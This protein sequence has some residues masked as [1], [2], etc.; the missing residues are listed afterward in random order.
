MERRL[1]VVTASVARAH[2]ARLWLGEPG[3][4]VSTLGGIVLRPHQ[5]DAIDRLRRTLTE[6]RAALLADDVG[7]GKTYVAIALAAEARQP[8]IVGP[9]ALRAMWQ[10]ALDAAGVSARWLSYERLSR[11]DVQSEAADLVILDEAHHARTPSARRYERLATLTAGA[12]L[13]LLSAT[14]IHN[15][16]SDLTTLFALALGEG[17]R[18]LDDAALAARIVRRTHADVPE[19]PLPAV[20]SSEWIRVPDDDAVLQQ[21]LALPPPVPPRNGGDG[22]ALLAWTLVRL[23]ASTR[24]AL[25][26]ALRRRAQRGFALRQALLAGVLPSASELAA[27][28]CSDRAVQ[29]AFAELLAPPTEGISGLLSALE[30]HVEAVESLRGALARDD[31]PDRAR[32]DALRSLRASLPDERVIVFTQFVDSAASLWRRLRSEPGVAVLTARGAH[33]AGGPLSRREALR[34]FAPRATGAPRPA[35]SERIGLL[36]CTDLLSEGVNLQD[37]STVV[38]LDLPWTHARLAQ[39]VGRVRRMGSPHRAV[40]VYTFAP[41]AAAEHLL[42]VER[43]IGEKLG[44]AAR[45]L[46]VAGAILPSMFR[47]PD[48]ECESSSRVEERCRTL[49]AGWSA[50]LP[51]EPGGVCVAGVRAPA[52]GTLVALRAR[53]GIRLAAVRDGHVTDDPRAVFLLAAAADAA[54]DTA[55]DVPA[56]EEALAAVARWAR[57]RGAERSAGGVLSIGS[58]A[59]RAV[60]QRL[61]ATVA[62]SPRARRQEAA[63]LAARARRIAAI[64][65]GV[66]GE[67]VLGRL[68]AAAMPDEAWLRSVAAFA[69]AHGEAVAQRPEAVEVAE[70]V[71]LI[72]LLSSSR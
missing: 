20:A 28:Q 3:R 12:R 34:R 14:P 59:G 36:I 47:V 38:H 60:L 45:T 37:A 61:A 44:A 29:L 42:A 46:G 68:A 18:T 43:R 69:E 70:P 24:G 50:S 63:E 8:L 6:Y 65:I 17:A 22:G 53:E 49:I 71:L 5:R 39:R 66:G 26:A 11:D 54:P 55:L 35:A 10:R 27:W 64:P 15:R 21:L 51:D 25:S 40:R 19:E 62:R 32:A 7:L 67:L 33:V 48:H 13:L 41:P 72:Q 30:R 9:A 2:L 4:G 16:R 58:R 52:P 56:L 23:W 31:G 1:N 57:A